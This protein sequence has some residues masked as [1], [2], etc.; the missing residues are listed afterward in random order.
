[1]FRNFPLVLLFVIGIITI[2]I[3]VR[4]IFM[5]PAYIINKVFTQLL[6]ALVVALAIIVVRGVYWYKSKG[7]KS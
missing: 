6:V 2:S 1:M 4:S 3:Y 7:R 5:A